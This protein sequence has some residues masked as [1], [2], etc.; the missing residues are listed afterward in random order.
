MLQ[1]SSRKTW[2]EPRRKNET[3][4]CHKRKNLKII[5][6]NIEKNFFFPNGFEMWLFWLP[7]HAI[8]HPSNKN[9]VDICKL[10]T[11]DKVS[12]ILMKKGKQKLSWQWYSWWRCLLCLFICYI[13]RS[14][15][16]HKN[17]HLQVFLEEYKY[18]VKQNKMT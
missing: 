9:K 5:S 12:Q 16:L 14:C 15:C 18:V 11:A 17:L 3:E 8:K 4:I 1:R 6:E 10:V 7:L 2:N 13:N